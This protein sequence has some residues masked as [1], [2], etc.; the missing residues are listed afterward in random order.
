MSWTWNTHG[1]SLQ[2]GDAQTATYHDIAE[3]YIVTRKLS[4]KLSADLWRSTFSLEIYVDFFQAVHINMFS[5]GCVFIGKS[6]KHRTSAGKDIS[7]AYE[8]R[9]QCSGEITP[10]S[11]AQRR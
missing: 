8:W 6:G 9:L 10:T 1:G 4:F 11:W 2:N 7:C 5:L 3:Q